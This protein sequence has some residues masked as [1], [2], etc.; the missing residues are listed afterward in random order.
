MRISD[1]YIAKQVL[2][3]TLFA[4]LVL[5]MVLLLGNLFQKIK[6]LLVDQQAPLWLVLQFVLNVLPM[7]LM[8]T[9]PWGFLTAVLMVFGRLSSDQEI[10]SF[11]VAG[12]SLARLS[13]PV[14]AI[15]VLLSIGSLWLN[16]TVV[17]NAKA[18]TEQL[19]FNQAT[20]DPDSLLKPGVVQGNLNGDK[21]DIQKILIDGKVGEWVEGFNFYQ[22]PSDPSKDRTYVHA[23]RAALSI[24][25]ANSQLRLKLEGA[26]FETLKANG[27]TDIAIAGRAEPLLIDLKNPKASKTRASLMTNREIQAQVDSLEISPKKKVR[28][29]AEITKRYSFSMAC[30]AFAFIAVPLGI[31]VRRT[32]SSS[33]LV[34]SLVIGAAYFIMTMLADQFKTD[35]GTSV[36]LW[37]PNVLCVLI[38]LLLFRR[39][40]FR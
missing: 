11:R 19:V 5:G 31:G 18:T 26:Y 14:F 12:V 4:V 37:S 34:A 23:D 6:P 29:R 36:M 7:S 17:P 16:V 28:M 24:D 2:K 27:Q 40:R 15:G 35:L 38:G 33:G 39:V 20:R 32:D 25:K 22:L 1:R 10:T 8:Y 9:V 3:G 13:A 21:K 30:L